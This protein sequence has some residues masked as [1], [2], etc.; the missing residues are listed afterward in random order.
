MRTKQ[1][2][3]LG[4]GMAIYFRQLKDEAV[5]KYGTKDPFTLYEKLKEEKKYPTRMI[6]KIVQM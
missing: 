1:E 4:P 3:P 2:A 6:K 5:E